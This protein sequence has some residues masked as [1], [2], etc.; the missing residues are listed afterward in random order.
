MNNNKIVIKLAIT[1]V[2]VSE[3][4]CGHGGRG[5]DPSLAGYDQGAQGRGGRG[6]AG[7][8]QVEGAIGEPQQAES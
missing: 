8:L 1:K 2:T 7:T 6:R 4:M 5:R 3:S